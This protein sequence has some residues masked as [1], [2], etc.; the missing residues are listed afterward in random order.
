[1]PRSTERG[2]PESLRGGG[3]E[4]QRRDLAGQV[5]TRASNR[6][7]NYFKSLRQI[8][9]DSPPRGIPPEQRKKPIPSPRAKYP[10]R[11]ELKGMEKLKLEL[12][13]EAQQL[14]S[15][16]SASVSSL[17]SV[18]ETAAASGNLTA[19]AHYIWEE[20][21]GG[22]V[23]SRAKWRKAKVQMRSDIDAIAM[24]APGR[25]G[26][27]LALTLWRVLCCDAAAEVGLRPAES[28]ADGA[29]RSC[30]NDPA[31]PLWKE[32]LEVWREARGEGLRLGVS[33][34]V[35]LLKALKNAKGGG[36]VSEAEAVFEEMRNMSMIRGPG[37][38]AAYTIMIRM[39]RT[40]GDCEKAEGAYRQMIEDGVPP[41]AAAFNMLLRSFVEGGRLQDVFRIFKEMRKIGVQIKESH[42]Y[43]VKRA[44]EMSSRPG[45][46]SVLFGLWKEMRSANIV[47]RRTWY[48]S[49]INSLSKAEGPSRHQEAM[50]VFRDMIANK[51][52]PNVVT[53]NC[54]IPSVVAGLRSR[55]RS[56][57]QHAQ[58]LLSDMQSRGIPPSSRTF[59]VLF[60]VLYAA[61]KQVKG[62]QDKA[63][64]IYEQAKK[65]ATVIETWGTITLNSLLVCM[66]GSRGVPSRFDVATEVYELMKNGSE[67]QKPN[68][69]TYS[70]MM[71]LAAQ[72]GNETDAAQVLSFFEEMKKDGI[73]PDMNSYIN[74][75]STQVGTGVL[76]LLKEMK[77]TGVQPSLKVYNTAIWALSDGQVQSSDADAAVTIM[78]MIKHD[79]MHPSTLT[80]NGM[81]KMFLKAK[82]PDEA[83][84][85]FEEMREEGRV[86][87]TA[88]TFK[89]AT[90]AF[91]RKSDAN[92]SSWRGALQL[93]ESYRAA[94]MAVDPIQRQTSTYIYDRVLEAMSKGLNE[95]G[96]V[97]WERAMALFNEMESSGIRVSP[98]SFSFVTYAVARAPGGSQWRRAVSFLNEM[99]RRKFQPFDFVVDGLMASALEAGGDALFEVVDVLEKVEK[100][101]MRASEK[102][103]GKMSVCL[104]PVLS[105]KLLVQL[106]GKGGG[107][108]TQSS[109]GAS[110][111]TIAQR[112][113]VLLEKWIVPLTTEGSRAVSRFGLVSQQKG[114]DA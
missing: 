66:K 62:R 112:F 77:E 51:I 105:S 64:Q 101:G 32:G 33:T 71:K 113:L 45:M 39:Y 70:L 40:V 15:F 78:R 106:C 21:K 56:G 79:G 18:L 95:F 81:I 63:Y 23:G 96:V 11:R 87:M 16:P 94:E 27:Q 100:L 46:S 41:N 102:K 84:S 55:D 109:A 57:W 43:A 80:Y 5:S 54:L 30:I 108:E 13:K 76:K 85:L 17:V 86:Q 110:H 28:V 111:R 72:S 58:L 53:Y 61:D 59:S 14:D 107:E 99:S 103:D 10:K 4:Y 75:M 3:S 82:R 26:A 93:L 114:S 104:D 83:W 38:G 29:I 52:E 1:M 22:F 42:Y 73:T 34:C 90:A 65:N 47:P 68:C 31:D 98:V 12:P 67:I 89:F 50:F 44:A 25:K 24:L 69:V 7:G 35:A 2:R 19:A 74:L 20:G 6:T 49:V 97:P 60:N 88:E 48:T 8:T 92:S 91:I 36:R 37:G 9:P